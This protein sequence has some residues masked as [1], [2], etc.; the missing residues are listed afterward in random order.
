[1]NY[2]VSF[3]WL[4]L[5]LGIESGSFTQTASVDTTAPIAVQLSLAVTKVGGREPRNFKWTSA[6]SSCSTGAAQPQFESMFSELAM[7]T[8]LL[9]RIAQVA[10]RPVKV[11]P[12]TE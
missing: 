8:A 6:S 2:D 3:T 11:K 1:M 7:R 9:H 12:D 10:H 4:V 5:C